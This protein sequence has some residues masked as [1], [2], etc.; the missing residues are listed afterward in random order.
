M[1]DEFKQFKRNHVWDFVPKLDGVNIIGTKWIFINKTNEFGNVAWSKARL[2]AQGYTQIEWIN[3]DEIFAPVARLESI[4][5]LLAVACVLNFTLYLMD[6]KTT[7]INKY[8][9]EDIYVSQP[10][11]FE[12]PKNANYVYKLRKVL[13]GLKQAL[14][15]WYKGLTQYLLKQGYNRG[16]L[17]RTLFVKYNGRHITIALIYVDDIVFGSTLQKYTDN[18]VFVMKKEFKMSMVGELTYLLGL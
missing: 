1:E 16:S 6:V 7:F 12:D 10:K 5:I 15:A 18:L 9:H 8:L 13:Y 4:H 2:V 11:G 14:R 17:Y 3:Y